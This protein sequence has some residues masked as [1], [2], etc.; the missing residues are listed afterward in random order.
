[1]Q[2]LDL[3]WG[4]PQGC[5][6]IRTYDG[7]AFR[8]APRVTLGYLLDHP[9]NRATRHSIRSPPTPRQL[10]VVGPSRI[11]FS[12]NRDGN[13]EIYV[14]QADGT[15]QTRLTNNAANDS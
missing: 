12:S 13:D 9:S 4:L 2:L 15:D 7:P 8:F 5:T 1:M 14:M 11:A 6:G 10:P 3:G